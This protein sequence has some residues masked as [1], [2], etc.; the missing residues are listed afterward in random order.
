LTQAFTSPH[1]PDSERRG[2]ITPAQAPLTA[3]PKQDV[4]VSSGLKA[5]SM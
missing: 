3:L 4:Q 1:G 5:M 2:S